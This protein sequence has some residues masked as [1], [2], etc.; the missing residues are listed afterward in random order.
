MAEQSA[1]VSRLQTL[2]VAL[3]EV[4]PKRMFGGYGLFLDG[5]MFA[6]VTRNDELFLKA[7]EENRD[8]F[9]AR[10]SKTHGKMPY[11]AA[12]PGCLESWREAEP[13]VRGAV[14]A[15]KRAKAKK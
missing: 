7:D 6:L 14:A 13:W 10:S 2:F 12:P 5:T 3:G 1:F 4:A 11:Y 15:S 8:S 9:I